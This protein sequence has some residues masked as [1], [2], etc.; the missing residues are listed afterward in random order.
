[1]RQD[2]LSLPLGRIDPN[3]IAVPM[4]D[5]DMRDDAGL[6]CGQK[7]LSA[8]ADRKVLDVLG[9]EIVQK[10]ARIGPADFDLGVS[11][12]I[13]QGGSCAGGTVRC[14]R[15]GHTRFPVVAESC[16]ATT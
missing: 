15:H 3:N 11:T 13:K 6:V 1:M 8:P 12:Q 7:R 14:I 5:P 10:A 9:A 2:L 4:S 16:A